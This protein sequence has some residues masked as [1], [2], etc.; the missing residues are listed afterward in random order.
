V[1]SE[2]GTLQRRGES[3]EEEEEEEVRMYGGAGRYD[4]VITATG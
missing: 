1:L 4:Q 3:M 2:K